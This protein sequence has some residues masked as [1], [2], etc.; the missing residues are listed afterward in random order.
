MLQAA[1][2]NILKSTERS[3][4]CKNGAVKKKAIVA[5]AR[6]LL[7]AIYHILSKNEPYNPA[8]YIQ[9]D[10]N[11]MARQISQEKAFEMLARMG[12]IVSNPSP[13]SSSG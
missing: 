9:E 5:I 11:P 12:F 1:V 10:K 4:R 6:R 2:K 13:L 8:A 3:R 7:T